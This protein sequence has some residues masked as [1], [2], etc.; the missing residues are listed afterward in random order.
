MEQKLWAVAFLLALLKVWSHL[1]HGETG[2]DETL[3]NQEG[4]SLN[5]TS[6]VKFIT[7]PYLPVCASGKSCLHDNTGTCLSPVTGG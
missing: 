7:E 3:G 5:F 2:G 4:N 1:F 6:S